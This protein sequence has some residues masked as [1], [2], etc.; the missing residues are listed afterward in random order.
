[1]VTEPKRMEMCMEFRALASSSGPDLR[2]GAD[3][4][5]ICGVEDFSSSYKSSRILGGCYSTC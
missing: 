5:A 3:I 1:M 4:C 2:I